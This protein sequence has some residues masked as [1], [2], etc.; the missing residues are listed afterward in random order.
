MIGDKHLSIRRKSGH[1]LKGAC[2]HFDLHG[3]FGFPRS[4]GH[5]ERGLFRRHSPR[6]LVK[7]VSVSSWP[8][9]PTNP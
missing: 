1:V 2:R 3:S 8:D 4:Y 5:V 7:R 9:T 6:F